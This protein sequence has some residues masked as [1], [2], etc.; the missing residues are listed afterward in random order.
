MLK[1]LLSLFLQD[2]CCLCDRT[3]ANIICSYCLNALHSHQLSNRGQ[4]W[5]GDLP[6]FAWGYYGGKLKRVIA[7]LKYDQHQQLGETLGYCLG[8]AWQDS[9]LA[10]SLKKA[11]VV[12]VPLHPHKQQIRG[13]NQADLIAKSFCRCTG[14]NYQPQGLQRVRDT[15][16]MFTLTPSQRQKNVVNAFQLG[17]K[18]RQ[19]IPRSPILLLDDI[20]TTGATAQAAAKT[21]KNAGMS[22]R[23]VLAIAVAKKI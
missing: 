23:G 18:F 17:K 8:Q 22:V 6:L 2:N 21:L 5:Q 9:H 12:P 19:R 10:P 4:F 1:S 3:S 14:L 11:L 15:E 13:F 16:A 20:F 7:A